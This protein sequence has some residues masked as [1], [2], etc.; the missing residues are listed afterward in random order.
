[1][2][3]ADDVALVSPSPQALQSLL[4]LSQTIT[5]SKQMVNVPEKTKLML[6]NPKSDQSATYWQEVT[7]ITMAGAALPLSSQAEHVGVLQCP[8]G[9]N[10]PSFI[11]RMAGHTK[12]LYSVISCGMARNHRGNPAASLRV[13]SSHCPCPSTQTPV[14][15]PTYDCKAWPQQ[16]PTQAQHL[17]SSPQHPKFLVLSSVRPESPVLPP[18]S[19][20]NSCLPIPKTKL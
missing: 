8:G 16:Y 7:P 2:G 20:T 17:H 9:S 12:S 10:L 14:H 13:E 11:S 4:N 18:K 1:M 6:F 5:S 15:T 3:V 19:P